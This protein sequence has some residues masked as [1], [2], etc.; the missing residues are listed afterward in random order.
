M[1]LLRTK[2]GAFKVLRSLLHPGLGG[3]SYR[4]CYSFSIG[5]F[6][7]CLPAISLLIRCTFLDGQPTSCSFH[8]VS[9]EHVC[10]FAGNYQPYLRCLKPVPQALCVTSS[11]RLYLPVS[12]SWYS[13]WIIFLDQFLNHIHPSLAPLMLISGPA[14]PLDLVCFH[15]FSNSVNV[16]RVPTVYQARTWYLEVNKTKSLFLI[17]GCPCFILS[18]KPCIYK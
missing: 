1:S 5:G 18:M 10:H 13:H 7:C 12:F 17:P 14:W 11:T 2:Y 3:G 6:C 8:R 16:Y 9:Q 4:V 15:L